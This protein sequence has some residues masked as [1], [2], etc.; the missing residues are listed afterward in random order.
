ML[1]P[2]YLS[3]AI[4]A[5]CGMYVVW[6]LGIRRLLLDL[7]REK[8]FELRFELFRLGTTGEIEFEDPAYRMLETLFCGLLRFG[9]RITF[10]SFVISKFAT[11]QAEKEKDYVNVSAQIALRVSQLRPETQA[12]ILEM[13]KG[14]QSIL[15]IYIGCSSLLFLSI[16]SVYKMLEILGIKHLGETKERVVDAIERE[17]YIAESRRGLQLAPA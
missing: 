2:I 1:N 16:F 7:M 10:L 15:M 9:H 11:S 13:L 3:S 17:A 12:K 5:V 4:A 6:A 14:I 8:I